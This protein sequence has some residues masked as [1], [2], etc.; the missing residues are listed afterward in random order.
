MATKWNK[1]D[2]VQLKSSGPVMT[3]QDELSTGDDYRCQWFA[4]KKLESG[5]FPT[6]SLQAATVAPSKPAE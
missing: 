5:V 4:G 1:G 2:L 3:V 6:E